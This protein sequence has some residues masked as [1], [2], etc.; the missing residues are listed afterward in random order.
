MK[1]L[2]VALSILLVAA[3]ATAQSTNTLTLTN[4]DCSNFRQ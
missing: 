4:S 2:L 1:H 3:F